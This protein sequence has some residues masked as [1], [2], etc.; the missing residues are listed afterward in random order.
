M[1]VSS[2]SLFCLYHWTASSRKAKT[3]SALQA[4]NPQSC[5]GT[6][7][8]ASSLVERM[9]VSGCPSNYTWAERSAAKVSEYS[10]LGA[11]RAEREVTV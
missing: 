2:G 1:E 7:R 4:A 9:C 3:K 6:W 5:H 10:Y 8:S 11:P